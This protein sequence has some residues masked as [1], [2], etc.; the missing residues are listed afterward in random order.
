MQRITPVI[1]PGEKTPRIDEDEICDIPF[2]RV[3]NPVTKKIFVLSLVGLFQI[4]KA[5]TMGITVAIIIAIPNRLIKKRWSFSIYTFKPVG[6]TLIISDIFSLNRNH[7][8]T[9]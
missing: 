7:S 4:I 8:S 6:I 2:T 5:T 3:T 1:N 9:L